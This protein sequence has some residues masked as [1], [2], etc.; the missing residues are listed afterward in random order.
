MPLPE[1]PETSSHG[2]RTA[3][4][5]PA[6]SIRGFPGTI[7]K[8]ATPVVSFTNNTF[9]Q[10][11][12]PSAVRYTPPPGLGAQAGP[13]APTKTTPGSRGS[14]PT[15]ENFPPPPHPPNFH[16]LPASSGK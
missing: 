13:I 16:L 2:C 11:L 4:H 1:P 8:S 12:P 9:C 7:I 3:C 14:P 10:V 15:P 6:N 5:I